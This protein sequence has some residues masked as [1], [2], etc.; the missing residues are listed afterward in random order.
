MAEKRNLQEIMLAVCN[1]A[2][3]LFRNNTGLAWV[4]VVIKITHKQSILVD[5]GD[6]V[7][8]NARPLH[9]GLV[10]GGADLIGYHTIEITPEMIGR[11]VAVFTGIEVK[12]D[13]KYAT[14]S[15]RTFIQNVQLAGGLAGVARNEE[16]ARA[17]LCRP[18]NGV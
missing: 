17:I 1:G 8:R 9:A 10:N 2:T 5:R 6:V 14:P 11:K 15:Q 16:E 12:D 7:I 4:G 3:K 18:P 13:G